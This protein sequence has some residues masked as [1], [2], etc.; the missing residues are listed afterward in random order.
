M[1]QRF[2]LTLLLLLT[3]ALVGPVTVEA[4]AT[5]PVLESWGDALTARVAAWLDQV[6]PSP[7][8]A[9]ASQ[10]TSDD[11]NTF[12]DLDPDGLSST[13]DQDPDDGDGNTFPNLDP[14]G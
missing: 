6:W 4:N 11:G 1:S 5:P 9:A 13:T 2:R 3:L 10:E 12:P 14:N 8:R 7:Q